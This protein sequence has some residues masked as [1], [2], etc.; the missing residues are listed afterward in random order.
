MAA[1]LAI[2]IATTISPSSRAASI[3]AVS[4]RD[5]S[6]DLTPGSGDSMGALL[7]RDGRY[8]LFASSAA[9]LL[10]AQSPVS[11]RPV[12]D[13]VGVYLRDRVTRQTTLLSSNLPGVDTRITSV[14][15]ADLSPDNRFVLLETTSMA[16]SPALPSS[17]SDVWLLDLTT[18]G[19]TL[20]SVNTNGAPVTGKS[21]SS[22]LTPDGRFI[23]FVSSA[24]DLAS[25]IT[26]TAPQVY[27]RDLQLGTT[28]LASPDALSSSAPARDPLLSDNGRYVLYFSIMTSAGKPGDLY[29]RDTVAG[30]TLAV[31]TNAR[32]IVPSS[33]SSACVNHSLSAD[34]NYIVFSL[35]GYV[36]QYEASSATTTTITSN[37][38][39]TVWTPDHARSVDMTDDGRFVVYLSAQGT[40]V[41]CWDR[42]A[43]TTASIGS[44]SPSAG[45]VF[46]SPRITP[47]GRYVC[48]S[49]SVPRPYGKYNLLRWDT[50]LGVVLPVTRDG[51]SVAAS[52][53]GLASSISTNGQVL[54]FDTADSDLTPA[55]HNHF[56][57]VFARDFTLST[58]ELISVRDASNLASTGNQFSSASEIALSS[59]GQFIV[60]MS[61]ADDLI[62]NYRNTNFGPVIF[63]RDLVAGTNRLVEVPPYA[64]PFE[65]AIS[66]SGGLIAF[67]AW[68][69]NT[70]DIWQY[71]TQ[72]GLLS[73]ASA[74]TNGL[75]HTNGSYLCTAPAIGADGRFV[76]F[77]ST[78]PDIASGVTGVA[79]NL[80]VHDNLANTNFALTTNSSPG[81]AY[82]ASLSPNGNLVSFVLSNGVSSP[83]LTVLALTN[84]QNLLSKSVSPATWIALGNS[85][86]AFAATNQLWIIDLATSNNVLAAAAAPMRPSAFSLSA[87]GRF[88]VYSTRQSLT[89]GDG[90]ANADVYLFDTLAG[91]NVLISVNYTNGQA[92]SGASD[93]PQ[94]SADN[95]FVAY[96]SSAPD[97]VPGDT[98]DV[99]DIF[100]YDRL[101]RSTTLVST[102]AGGNASAN[103]RSELP[104]FSADAKSLFFGSWSGNLA[105][106]DYNQAE[107]I[108]AADLTAAAFVDSDGDGMDDAWE[109]QFFGSLARDGIGDFDGD[110]AT[111][112]AEFIAGTDPSDPGSYLHLDFSI[113]AAGASTLGWPALPRRTYRVQYKND[114]SDAGWSDLAAPIAIVGNQGY[115]Y[116][117]SRSS[118]Q[119]FYR[120]LLME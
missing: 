24:R 86:V 39:S 87:D 94:I 71:Q 11:L 68:S 55:D 43:G 111:D 107:D 77:H 116:D 57:D 75:A 33:S 109:M 17:R 98:N 15:P 16:F 89:A 114:L 26:N 65:P 85:K 64:V 22:T 51:S 23:G 53:N 38:L 41:F 101:A 106:G 44:N 90:N 27:L 112:L 79:D 84:R 42:L 47:D 58:N 36:L 30:T 6:A 61:L 81:S 96:R 73:L 92:P 103:Q 74:A 80:F 59:N 62:S 66:G 78:A 105:A 115:A 32:T 60:F 14:T 49:A 117:G 88:L 54:A 48:V 52:L 100:L 25:G 97:I 8:V 35:L 20:V 46:Q 72:S 28:I 12:P 69:S 13:V 70:H 50:V 67:S 1:S 31:S 40:N 99:P 5:P 29:L 18:G 3:T 91:T 95:R 108:F 102:D 93:W 7:S 2:L 37:A 34:G 19:I 82:F 63:L 120:L 83:T 113:D 21:D 10:P 76:L 45:L 118:A 104:L 56:Y 119:R 4:Q 9:D 110:G